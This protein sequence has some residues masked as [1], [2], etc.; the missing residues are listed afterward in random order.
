MSSSRMISVHFDLLLAI[1]F[2]ILN[3][4]FVASEFAIVKIRPT[5]LERATDRVVGYVHV[6]DFLAALVTG[7]KPS[8][9]RLVRTALLFPEDTPLEDIRREM[10][11]KGDPPG[12]R[13]RRGR[14]GRGS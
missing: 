7:E 3:S 14:G 4:F 5:L 13:D 1:G 2:V 6:K 10:Q 11:R 9:R 12:D 8:L